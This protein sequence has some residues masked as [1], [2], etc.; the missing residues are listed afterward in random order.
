[1]AW[2]ATVWHPDG[3][4]QFDSA[5][6]ALCVRAKGRA[7]GTAVIT[8]TSGR[9]PVVA[10]RPINCNAAIEGCTRSG[11]D[12][13]YNLSIYQVA[14]GGYC[15][16]W[17]YDT[18]PPTNPDSGWSMIFMDDAGLVTFNAAYPPMRIV[19]D[20]AQPSGRVYAI[21]PAVGP[22]WQEQVLTIEDTFGNI[23]GIDWRTRMGGW[24]FDGSYFAT[25]MLDT[26]FHF[27]VTSDQSYDPAQS[28][29]LLLD[30]TGH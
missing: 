16:W 26:P 1:M 11:A 25:A 6:P 14:S 4:V 15:D 7:T 21:A 27:G 20:E 5:W 17:V 22:A 28:S 9:K 30:V 12:Y 29:Y 2:G 10:I 13:S 24:V 8:V 18:P 19:P 23:V 3:R